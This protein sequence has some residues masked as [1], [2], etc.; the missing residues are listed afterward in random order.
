M[1]LQE[2]EYRRDGQEK[3]DEKR[4][5]Y[6]AKETT[7][8]Y[9]RYRRSCFTAGVRQAFPHPVLSFMLKRNPVT[10]SPK[11]QVAQ[12]A[13]SVQWD[14][15][16]CASSIQQCSK[17]E[18]KREGERRGKRGEESMTAY[19]QYEKYIYA[20]RAVRCSLLSTGRISFRVWGRIKNFD[21]AEVF[22]GFQRIHNT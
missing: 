16:R 11:Y 14:L 10:E 6:I 13:F 21:S 5:G 7:G 4:Y 15:V 1:Q 8:V 17:R 22:C 9:Y 20:F 19:G 12:I 2:G 18:R 3:M